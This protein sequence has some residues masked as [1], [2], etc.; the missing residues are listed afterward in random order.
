MANKS[1]GKGWKTLED[2]GSGRWIYSK[3]VAPSTWI[4][5][6]IDDMVD[7][8]GRDANCYFCCDVGV[9]DLE[10]GMRSGS[11]ASALESC[12]AK[13]WLF[14]IPVENQQLAM[15]QCLFDYGAYS[16][17]WRGSSPEVDKT[18]E[19]WS[20][21]VP[22]E[23]SKEFKKLLRSAKKWAEENLTDE[24][25]RNHLLDTKIVNKLGQTAR[26]YAGGTE[27]LWNTLRQIRD[28]PEASDAQKLFLKM[29]QMAGQTFGAGPV[30]GDIVGGKE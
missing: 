24:D 2:G 29:Y 17:V 7:A 27:S 5:L 18:D 16:P 1:I 23:G 19:D 13:S 15:A 10:Q 22:D 12:D 26:E 3:K 9:V 11:L 14:D 20:F 30:P 4:F 25:D 8:C 21:N 6:K 28:N